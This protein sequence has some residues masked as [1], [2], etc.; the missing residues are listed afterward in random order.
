MRPPAPEYIQSNLTAEEFL[1]ALEPYLAL[2]IWQRLQQYIEDELE[3]ATE[4]ACVV[5][6]REKELRDAQGEAL[7]ARDLLAGISEAWEELSRERSWTEDR[8]AWDEAV[9]RMERNL[10]KARSEGLL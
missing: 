5:E 9:K 6:E 4:Q 7:L 3:S 8:R 10:S 2:A 1:R